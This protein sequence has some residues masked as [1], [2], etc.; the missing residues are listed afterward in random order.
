MYTSTFHITLAP[1]SFFMG[2]RADNYEN[3]EINEATNS[4]SE[5]VDYQE[6]V[7]NFEELFPSNSDDFTTIPDGDID[8]LFCGDDK[9]EDVGDLFC[10]DDKKEDIDDLFGG[11]EDDEDEFDLALNN[12]E[13]ADMNVHD[14]YVVL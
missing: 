13:T 11:G 8:D 3:L 12:N 7:E 5:F 4:D 9:K 10:G 1:P 2:G 14:V 6:E